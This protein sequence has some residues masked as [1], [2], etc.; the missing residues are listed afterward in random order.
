MQPLYNYLFDLLKIS[1]P[2]LLDIP[3][4]TYL[5]RQATMAWKFEAV[6]VDDESKLAVDGTAITAAE[7]K[8]QCVIAFLLLLQTPVNSSLFPPRLRF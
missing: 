4:Y 6:D 3:S 1:P 5:T 2:T 8:E 7:I